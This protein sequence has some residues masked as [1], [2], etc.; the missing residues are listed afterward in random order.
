MKSLG[1]RGWW[2]C[3]ESRTQGLV[4]TCEEPRTQGLVDTCR[5]LPTYIK[6]Y[7]SNMPSL[8]IAYRPIHLQN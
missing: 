1:H 8:L 5:V 4:G 6:A 3:E 2:K 7:R